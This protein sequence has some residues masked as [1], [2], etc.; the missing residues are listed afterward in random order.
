MPSATPAQPGSRHDQRSRA[1]GRAIIETPPACPSA[2]LLPGRGV[3]LT[4][5]APLPIRLRCCPRWPRGCSPPRPPR[6][7]AGNRLTGFSSARGHA[8]AAG[9]LQACA[10]AADRA[11]RSEGQRCRPPKLP[12]GRC[13]VA[14][15]Y[16][17]A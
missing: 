10:G 5:T 2:T 1:V 7:L 8:D 16:C 6:T 9:R 14:F 3:V 13:D 4:P 12:T 11:L 15:C 17:R